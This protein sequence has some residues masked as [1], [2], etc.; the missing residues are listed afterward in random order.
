MAVKLVVEHLKKIELTLCR[1]GDTH[2]VNLFISPVTD[3]FI[4]KLQI[5]D[6]EGQEATFLLTLQ[7]SNSVNTHFVNSYAR[8]KLSDEAGKCI[9][10]GENGVSLEI[11]YTNYGDPFC[12][13]MRFSFINIGYSY[14]ETYADVDDD[15]LYRQYV[16]DLQ[17]FLGK[18]G[19]NK[20][21]FS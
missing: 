17:A 12:E 20:S 8:K 11:D 13:A 18:S 1:D 21:Y 19:T 14:I 2:R 15:S 4:E 9:L 5:I 3:F 7:E 6:T 10:E 16:C